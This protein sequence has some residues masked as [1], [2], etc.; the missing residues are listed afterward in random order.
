MPSPIDDVGRWTHSA[1][2]MSGANYVLPSE[3]LQLPYLFEYRCYRCNLAYPTGWGGYRYY[4]RESGERVAVPHSDPKIV[5]E[6][7]GLTARHAQAEGRAGFASYCLCFDC[8]AQFDL[9]VERDVKQCPRCSSLNVR[10][11]RGSVGALCPSCKVGRFLE[12]NTGT[13]VTGR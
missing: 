7:T 9:D 10:T 12:H 6:V 1:T 11:A 13:H 4:I 2:G 5:Y 8:L 3:T